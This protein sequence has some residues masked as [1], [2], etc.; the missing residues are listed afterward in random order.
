M[1]FA[2]GVLHWSPDVFWRSTMKE[3]IAA[4]EGVQKAN[5]I[6]D[7]DE[8]MSLERFM[9]LQQQFPDG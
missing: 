6:P 2:F 7:Q 1:E 5:K 4:A 9:E 3:L 8:P